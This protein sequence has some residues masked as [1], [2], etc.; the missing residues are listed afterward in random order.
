MME[1]ITTPEEIAHLRSEV[2]TYNAAAKWEVIQPDDPISESSLENALVR[3]K[4]FVD[5]IGSR[6]LS[7]DY[8]TVP[9][10]EKLSLNDLKNDAKA[11]IGRA[12]CY[13]KTVD[14]YV[15]GEDRSHPGF[16]RRVAN[17][18]IG[19]YNECRRQGC[20][21]DDLYRIMILWFNRQM[22]NMA[23]EPVAAALVAYLFAKCD[24]FEKTEEEK[25][26]AKPI[27]EVAA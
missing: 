27:S 26:V 6:N 2:T 5:K 10:D 18:F 12:M 13:Y 24:I 19:L 4:P 23:L 9:I 21:G 22:G 7:T 15:R 17:F 8:K 25:R 3:L 20:F 16:H 14:A 1:T 11:D